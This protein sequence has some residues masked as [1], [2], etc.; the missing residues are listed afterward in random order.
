VKPGDAV[1]IVD[2][3][4]H[5]DHANWSWAFRDEQE[6]WLPNWVLQMH[7]ENTSTDAAPAMVSRD[8]HAEARAQHR[9]LSVGD[10]DMVLVGKLEMVHVHKLE[11]ATWVV[12]LDMDS[13]RRGWIP[14][15][16]L[17]ALQAA[18]VLEPFDARAVSEGPQPKV[19]TL[20]GHT[21]W[22]SSRKYSGWIYV[23][24]QGREG[25]IPTNSLLGNTTGTFVGNTNHPGILVVALVG[26][27]LAACSIVAVFTCNA[28]L[29]QR[30]KATLQ[31]DTPRSDVPPVHAES[32]NASAETRDLPAGTWHRVLLHR[33]TN[34][35]D[36]WM[37]F[38]STM[39]Y[40]RRKQEVFLPLTQDR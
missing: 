36:S 31:T 8:F 35:R 37:S 18:V 12:A 25:W 9:Q 19:T 38:R 6:G 7:V 33:V 40:L 29:W 5:R 15:G 4:R 17:Q 34:W 32:S 26:L 16:V 1:W 23:C 3:S 10:G 27:M 28:S 20:Q 13:G 30:I 14:G 11:A 39:F 21:V 2:K 24:S 22:V